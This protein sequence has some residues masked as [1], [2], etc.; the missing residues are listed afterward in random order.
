MFGSGTSKPKRQS[1]RPKERLKQSFQE[2][3]YQEHP[4]V[5][6]TNPAAQQL[7]DS[8]VRAAEGAW[9][10]KWWSDGL[11]AESQS[12]GKNGKTRSR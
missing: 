10:G 6:E 3:Q 12:R 7:M 9:G 11:A 8:I 1:H 4:K 2:W 5:P